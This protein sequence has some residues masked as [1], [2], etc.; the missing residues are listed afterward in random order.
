[1]TLDLVV[2]LMRAG[3]NE[4]ALCVLK[5]A[6][7]IA[8]DGTAP[9]LGY[10]EAA[11][12]ALLGLPNEE[13]LERAKSA[14]P[15]YCFPARLEDIAVLSAAPDDDPWAAFYLGCLLYDRRRHHEA[16][17]LWHKAVEL[18]PGNAL[19]F[20]CL[21]IAA[22]N[23]LGDPSLAK[24]CYDSAIAAAPD[25]SRLWHERDQLWKRMGVE[26]SIRLAELEKRRDLVSQRD[27]LTIEFCALLNLSDRLE[28]AAEILASRRFQ[29]WEGGEGQSLGI[30][31]RTHMALSRKAATKG[32]LEDALAELLTVLNPPQNLGEARHLLSNASDLW[33]S[34]GDV[35]SALGRESEAESWWLRAAEFRGDFQE[36]AVQAFSELTYFQA[37]ALK[38]LGRIQE[39]EDLLKALKQYAHQQL[40]APAKIDYF[41]TSLPTM[42]LFED[43]LKARQDNRAR[44][45]LAQAALAE[46]QLNEA[47]VLLKEVLAQDPSHALARELLTQS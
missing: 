11:L 40:L 3:L 25:D 8:R 14:C 10:Y 6:D 16:A 41:A 34:L 26:P 38:R 47:G 1:M 35:C 28:E 22:F 23:V 44:L 18:E 46:G 21:G 4:E 13:A 15:D 42:L 2:D 37:L 24:N 17:M 7:Q 36:M 39:C 31:S 29:P 33:L 19:A 20:R 30:Y 32:N 12:L 9:M 45:I 5:Q 27:D 43:D